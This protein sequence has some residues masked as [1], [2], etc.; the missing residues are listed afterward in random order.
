MQELREE[1]E[2]SF[3]NFFRSVQYDILNILDNSRMRCC[4]S[5]GCLVG[6]NETY[7]YVTERAQYPPVAANK[8]QVRL[9]A[10]NF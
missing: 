10:A 6:V 8:R 5:M 9:S 1:D 4:I 3:H 7:L 2:G